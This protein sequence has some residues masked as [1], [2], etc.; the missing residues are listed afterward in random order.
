MSDA[1]LDAVLCHIVHLSRG[2]LADGD[3][4]LHIGIDADRHGQLN[5]P[6]GQ[7]SLGQRRAREK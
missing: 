1:G 3:D 2:Q 7:I 5:R 4:V 6:L